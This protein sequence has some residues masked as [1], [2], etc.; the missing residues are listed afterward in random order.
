[1]TNSN[2]RCL[3]T[4]DRQ[5]G[6]AMLAGAAAYGLLLWLT[7]ALQL[8]NL[9]VVSLAPAVAIPI[10]CGLVWGPVAGFV[11]G[12]LGS[13]LANLLSPGLAPGLFWMMGHGLLGLVAGISLLLGRD[14]RRW[15]DYL[16]AEV[17]T[18]AAVYISLDYRVLREVSY[19]A[20][21]PSAAWEG[22]FGPALLSHSVNALILVPA[23]LWLYHRWIAGR[24]EA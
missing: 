15:T 13:A 10:F 9:L 6:A 5:R 20:L 4:V 17:W 18:L 14:Y 8:P 2:L 22:V 12:A 23:L 7:D 24:E 19:G 21:S 11:A 1:M 16:L 3:W